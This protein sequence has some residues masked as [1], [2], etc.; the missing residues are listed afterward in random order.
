MVTEQNT[1]PKQFNSIRY[2]I[3]RF[4]LNDPT[5]PSYYMVGFKL[6]CDLNQREHYVETVVG[7][8]ECLN[9][10]DNEICELAYTQLKPKIDEISNDLLKKRFIVGSEFVP[11]KT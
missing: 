5:T 3:N 10:S 4:E 7:Y 6:V 8:S 9:K 2:I 1:P 11:P